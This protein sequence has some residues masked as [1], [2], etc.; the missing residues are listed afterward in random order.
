MITALLFALVLAG[1]LLIECQEQSA[2]P[3][4]DT[5]TRGSEAVN[6]NTTAPKASGSGKSSL[7]RKLLALSRQRG[8]FSCLIGDD[9]KVNSA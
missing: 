6:P 3:V 8:D 7:A 4:P 5:N 1:R 2:N 9:I